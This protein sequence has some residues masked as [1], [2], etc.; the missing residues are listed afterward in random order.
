MPPKQTSEPKINNE[1]IIGILNDNNGVKINYPQLLDKLTKNSGK[2]TIK[3]FRAS[4]TTK[5]VVAEDTKATFKK[6]KQAFYVTP[7][8]LRA[9]TT[10]KNDLY[11]TR[12]AAGHL[13]DMD[14]LD[15]LKCN[16]LNGVDLKSESCDLTCELYDYQ[17]EMIEKIVTDDHS[18]HPSKSLTYVSMPTGSGKTIVG[19]GLIAERKKSTLI[20]VPTVEIA[21]QWIESIKTYL[22]G[23][24]VC[25]LNKRIKDAGTLKNY[26][27]AVAVINTARNLVHSDVQYFGQI[28]IDEVHETYTKVNSN[29][30][31]LAQCFKFGVGFSATPD[32]RKDGLDK[33]VYKFLG[34]PIQCNMEMPKYKF[35]VNIIEYYGD[36]EFCQ[37]VVNNGIL[38]ATSTIEKL[39]KEPA[40]VDLVCSLIKKLVGEGKSI[41]VFTEHRE[42][43]PL[44]RDQLTKEYN[45][46]AGE[47]EIPELGILRGGVKGI[48]AKEA[49]EAKIVLTTYGFSRRGLSIKEKVA[50]I[51]ATPR[52]TPLAQ[53]FGRITRTGG[54]SI[55]VIREVYYIMDMKSPIKGQADSIKEFCKTKG[56]E[57]SKTKIKPGSK[58]IK[59]ETVGDEENDE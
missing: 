30:L 21:D 38:V 17:L 51:M 47:M 6:K 28:L 20:V 52:R 46:L 56:Y 14:I 1:P 36:N 50:L 58:S 39:A 24:R 9:F 25:L 2:F 54:P 37:P 57:I 13:W 22:P 3:K 18:W 44:Y 23:L 27:I 53:L 59:D 19:C 45:E 29:V 11:I 40:R 15:G 16:I 49:K 12:I 10:D 8:T 55:D 48:E 41:F 35:R 33:H 5:Q 7:K 31:W 4:M 43:L 32:D 42:L 26:D 34:Q